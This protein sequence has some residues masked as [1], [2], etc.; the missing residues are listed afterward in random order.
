MDKRFPREEL[1]APGHRGCAGCGASILVRMALKT[2]GRDVIVVSATGCLEVFTTPYPETA[3]RVPWIHTAFEC[4]GAVAS[5]IERA[6]KALKKRGKFK[7]RKIAVMPII[8]DG[9]TADIGFQALSGA[10]ERGHDMVYIMYDNEAYMNTGVQRSSATPLFASATTAPAG[11][12]SK[13]EDRPKKDMAMIAAA[14]GIPYVATAC[15]SYPEDLMKK[16]KKAY[17]I[18]GPAFIHVLQP[19]TVG[20][21][22]NPEDTIKIGRLA[23]ETG[24]F[25][26]YEIEHG[27]LRI[28]YRPA[29]RKPLKEYIRMQK[30][31]RHLTDEDIEILQ[32][33]VDEKCK[34][35][36]LE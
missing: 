20:W 11:K 16:I 34:L 23:V 6:I 22:Y 8:G 24:F 13:G 2:T 1:F 17:E 32:K 33:Y 7:D 25:P 19:C 30:R 21:G 27:E 35:L 12:R 10:L 18:E 4:G 3:W 31:Y 9:G 36:G 29:K 14:H 5:G 28:T 15:I 26:L